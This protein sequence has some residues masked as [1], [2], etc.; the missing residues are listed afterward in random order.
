MERLITSQNQWEK[1][2]S[3]CSPINEIWHLNTPKLKGNYRRGCRNKLQAGRWRW[4]LWDALPGQS[5]AV[6]SGTPTTYD[7]RCKTY[8]SRAVLSTFQH[9][10]TWGQV[11]E[12]TLLNKELVAVVG[13]WGRENQSS[14]GVAMDRVL[15]FQWMIMCAA[16]FDTAF[17]LRRKEK[18]SLKFRGRHAG[19]LGKS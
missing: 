5:T 3:M 6:H 13:C 4:V 14:L 2:N 11:H 9:R 19:I 7:Y 16:L 15:I 18:G 17:Y 12:A 1:W 8:L 10:W